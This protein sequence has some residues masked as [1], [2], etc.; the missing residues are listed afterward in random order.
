[1]KKIFFILLSVLFLSTTV[2]AQY[3]SKEAGELKI[4]A[5]L[6]DNMI[7]QQSSQVNLW[8]EG[9]PDS[10]VVIA[11][12]WNKSESVVKVNSKGR[13]E[14]KITTPSAT[15]ASQT[16]TI[17]NGD[18]SIK[19]EN[20]LIG[21]VWFGSGQS[22]MEMPL[23]GFNNC[24]INGAN[25]EVALAANNKLV[26]YVTIKR[27]ASDTPQEYC[28]SD[29]WKD[30]N[31]NNAPEFGATAYYFAKMLSQAL[32]IPVGIVNCSWG[33]SSVE[34]WLP[35]EIVETYKDIKIGAPVDYEFRKPFIM[36]NGM[37]KASSKYTVKGFLWYQ[38]ES[39][40][41]KPDYAQR[42]STMVDLWRKM[43]QQGELPF[44]EVEIAPYNYGDGTWGARLREQQYKAQS[45]ISN[46]GMISTNDLVQPFEL[47]Q[48]HPMEKE[49]VGERLC[50]M[51]LNNTYGY[52]TVGCRGPEYKNM[53]TD[54]D[55]AL[56]YF[57]NVEA[58][59]NRADGIEGFEIAGEDKKFY[60]A[61]ATMMWQKNCIVV[62]APEVKTPVAV[63]YCFKN[64][65][66]GNLYNI[67]Q[68]PAVPFR[69]DNWD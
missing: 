27:T 23:K 51:A 1:M 12:S 26:R 69:T 45:I 31:S 39:N 32:G 6:S 16:I 57:N 15:S 21:E 48:I 60:P 67:Y 24:P 55:K 29:G 63:R 54:A 50:N 13:W 2:K 41:G 8:G 34:G 52:K 17:K 28:N 44:Y 49:K 61:K 43:W 56:I 47:N 66:I 19:L 65:Q 10:K 4:P 5:L 35:R 36:Y 64:F 20:V 30:C 37:L 40:V 59:Y 11:T 22:N 62:T 7:L 25:K 3:Y 58:G 68:L 18:R 9:I 38:G 53:E 14:T 46:S 42:L 33:G